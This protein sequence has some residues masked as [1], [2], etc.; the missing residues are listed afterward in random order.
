MRKMSVSPRQDQE[1]VNVYFQSR[2]SFW[3]DVYSSRGVFAEIIRDRH[4]AVLAWI[5]SLAL[6]PGSRVLEVGCGAGFMAV[7]L[8]Q[9]GLHVHAI[10]SVEAMVELTRQHAAESGVASRLSVAA[11]DVYA[12]D[13]EDDSFDLVLALGVIPWLE[14]PELAIQEMARVTQPAGHVILTSTNRASLPMLLDPLCNPVLAPLKHRVRKALE[15]LGLLPQRS[16]E[17]QLGQ[18]YHPCRFIDEALARAGLAKARDT[19]LGFEFSLFR[20]KVIP[21]PLATTLYHRLQ[22][23]A[24]RNVLGFGSLGMSYHVLARKPAPAALR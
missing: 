14:W 11:G 12:L 21:E 16:A 9:R 7:A 1:Q 20:H 3:R 10:D 17:E 8:A 18:H 23:L 2:S 24:D 22:H 19:T 5:D 15:R 6:A 4:T 13:F